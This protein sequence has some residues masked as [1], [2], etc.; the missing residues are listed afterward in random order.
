M[1]NRYND[2][3]YRSESG[4]EDS[5]GSSNSGTDRGEREMSAGERGRSMYGYG[6]A[7]WE[8]RDPRER[9][10]ESRGERSWDDRERGWSGSASRPREEQSFEGSSPRAGLD[11]GYG[12]DAPSGG[13]SYAERGRMGGGMGESYAGG[14]RAGGDVPRRGL[15]GELDYGGPSAYGIRTG[16]GGRGGYSPQRDYGGGGGDYARGGFGTQSQGY[17]GSQSHGQDHGQG[18]GQGFRQGYAQS[19]G[20]SFGGPQ[21]YG[22]TQDRGWGELGERSYGGN[23]DDRDEGMGHRMM[24]GIKSV[25]RGKGPKG[26][27]RSDERIR[28]DVLDRLNHLSVHAEVDASEVEAAVEDGEVTLTGFVRERRWKHM[29]EDAAEGVMGVKDIHNQIRVRREDETTRATTTTGM[30]S[31]MGAT[32]SSTTAGTSPMGGDSNR[33]SSTGA[34]QRS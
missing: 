6:N 17:G 16:V 27:K 13:G 2:E 26:Y 33:R 28:E 34:A 25:F 9:S 3:G 1:R 31:G 29:M 12:Y 22:G 23:R 11:R 18:Y 7:S 19:Y 30:T 20:R 8:D 10:S 32:A 4:R 14:M 5:F 15:N 24:E 21:S